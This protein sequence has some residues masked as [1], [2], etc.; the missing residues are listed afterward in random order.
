MPFNPFEFFKELSIQQTAPSGLSQRR[1]LAVLDVETTGVLQ[2][3]DRVIEVAVILCNNEFEVEEEF[4][5]LINPER[6]LGEFHGHGITA[7]MLLDAPKF[8]DVAGD[9]VQR[10]R[11][12]TLVG[13]N[14]QFDLA[15]L[16]SEYERLGLEVPAPPRLCT[17]RLAYKLGPSKRRLIDCCRHHGIVLDNA[18]NALN[19]ARATLELLRFYQRCAE[20]QG[21]S[22]YS[23][24][25][26]YIDGDSESFPHIAPSGVVLTR[27]DCSSKPSQSYLGELISQLRDPGSAETATYYSALDRVLEDRR[28][29]LEEVEGLRELAEQASLSRAAVIEAHR[30]YLRGLVVSALADE[31]ISKSEADDL[32]CVNHLLGFEPTELQEL[33]ESIKAIPRD[34]LMRAT[35]SENDVIGK[36]VC[37]TGALTSCISGKPISRQQALE[38]VTTKGLIATDSVT[39]ATDI[40]VLADPD[41]MSGKAKKAR[42][43]GIRLMSDR[44][45]WLY[46][47]VAVD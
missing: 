24:L 28:V 47:G 11:S 3:R 46:I 31:V 15:L 10:L 26:S 25:D 16:S 38:L 7:G 18:H 35:A 30:D 40:L 27:E 20:K 5:T 42:Q 36:R 17:L 33:I 37:F 32:E 41:S 6:D 14:I 19:D 44:A 8:R 21:Y 13:H 1:P 12:R 34:L 22:I 2:K 23:D 43:Y 29:T 45:F 9:I 39:K 4:T